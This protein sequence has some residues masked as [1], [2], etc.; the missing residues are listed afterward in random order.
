MTLVSPDTPGAT[1]IT[2]WHLVQDRRPERMAAAPAGAVLRAV[3][4]GAAQTSAQMYRDVGAAWQWV[5]RA[6]WSQEQWQGWVAS[7]G[8]R[9]LV[10]DIDGV[11]AG[12]FELIAVTP[13]TVQIAF[14]GLLPG[15]TGNGVGRWLLEEAVQAAWSGPGVDRVRLHTCAL[16]HPAALPNY[17]ARGFTVERTE[18]EWRLVDGD[19]AQ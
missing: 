18:V 13:A 7:P 4:D 2:V 16:D 6:H 15:F 14:F 11:R 12:Y 10:L 9:L 5:D 1:A 3:D 17:Q 8:Y 19:R